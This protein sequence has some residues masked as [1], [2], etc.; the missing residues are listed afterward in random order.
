VVRLVP[1]VLGAADGAADETFADG[2]IEHPQYTQPR[3]FRS[4]AVPEVLLSGDHK[5]IAQWRLEQRKLRTQQRRPDL[6]AAYLESKD[7]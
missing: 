5:K 3:E 2:L 7:S 6:W 4:M 1:G